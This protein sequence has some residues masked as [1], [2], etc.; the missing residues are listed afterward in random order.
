MRKRDSGLTALPPKIPQRY[1]II[2]QRIA[3]EAVDRTQSRLPIVSVA[4]GSAARSAGALAYVTLAVALAPGLAL[5]PA[6]AHPRA[7]PRTFPRDTSQSASCALG[8]TSLPL[9]LP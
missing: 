6:P 1:D 5:T 8:Y 3:K 4:S 7:H 9:P 2:L